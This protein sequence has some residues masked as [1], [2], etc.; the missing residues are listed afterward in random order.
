MLGIEGCRNCEEFVCGEGQSRSGVSSSGTVGEEMGSLAR[1][2][3]DHAEGR[4]TRSR[5]RQC[6]HAPRT[7]ALGARRRTGTQIIGSA[8]LERVAISWT[9]KEEVQTAFKSIPNDA[10][11]NRPVLCRSDTHVRAYAFPSFLLDRR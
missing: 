9:R 4:A 1:V 3:Q 6:R 5:D 2:L 8:T 7:K 10:N 11:G